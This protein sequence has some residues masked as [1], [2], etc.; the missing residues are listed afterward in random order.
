MF[1]VRNGAETM[2]EKEINEEIESPV[3]STEKKA[4]S[5]LKR[6][7]KKIRR[8]TVQSAIALAASAG[9]LIGGLFNSPADLLQD[10]TTGVDR[11]LAPAAI[12]M[13]ID[14]SDEDP[15]P[16]TD[17][18]DGGDAA[19]QADDE[20]KRRGVKGALRSIILKTPKSIRAVFGIPMWAVGCAL[21]A[22]FNAVLS[23]L[24]S[25]VLAALLGWVLTAAVILLCIVGTVK[26]VLPDV[27]MKKILNKNTILIVV[28]GVAF[29][30]AADSILPLV[31]TGYAAV[32]NILRFT[33]AGAVLATASSVFI[34]REK[35]NSIKI[36]EAPAGENAG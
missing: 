29:F 11:A 27:P 6:R 13:V 31:W 2:E 30:A 4:E 7:L 5:R 23:A 24:L 15:D 3:E 32:R 35:K 12:E 33:G 17:G 9:V 26:T 21:I 19:A 34:R 10:P 25:P 14:E 22:L 28:C 1:I 36:E 16:D 8:H 20:E 18:G